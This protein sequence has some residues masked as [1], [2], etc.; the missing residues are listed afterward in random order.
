ME[1]DKP[2]NELELSEEEKDNEEIDGSE[3]FEEVK[4]K[5]IIK[6]AIISSISV[7]VIVLIFVGL[8]FF[9]M[10]GND[11]A[12]KITKEEEKITSFKES[13]AK[14]ENILSYPI[15]NI[16]VNLKTKSKRRSSYLKLSLAL[17]T[18][19]IEKENFSRDDVKAQLDNL[20]PRIKDQFQVYLRELEPSD[21]QG[22]SGMQRVR[23]ELLDRAN[24]VSKPIKI[25]NILFL[26]FLIQ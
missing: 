4:K 13:V 3:N 16:L 24:A 17:E 18:E 7:F 11:S 10:F 9:G 5:K 19:V 15:A 12:D 23:E 22:S 8:F 21:L 14:I 20:S 1:E 26:E 6:I 2:D 25:S